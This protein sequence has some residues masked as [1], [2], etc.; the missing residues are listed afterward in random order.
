MK[1]WICACS[2]SAAGGRCQVR[3][4]PAARRSMLASLTTICP[5]S[6]PAVEPPRPNTANSTP[7]SSRKCSSGSRSSRT[8]TRR[9]SALRRVPDRRGVG[10]LLCDHRHLLGHLHVEVLGVISCP[11]RRRDFEHAHVV[12]GAQRRVE[13]GI[14]PYRDQ[15][16][17]ADR[18]CPARV[19]YVH[20][21][22]DRGELALR[23]G[24][25][26]LSVTPGHVVDLLLQG[27]RLVLPALDD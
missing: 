15:L 9:L 10:A 18:V 2:S 1:S 21:V 14:G 13:V 11:P 27:S 3:Q 26:L 12:E 4:N 7:P 6:T 19:R 5:S 22:A 17:I 8:N 25:A 24:L 16:G 23:I 20:R